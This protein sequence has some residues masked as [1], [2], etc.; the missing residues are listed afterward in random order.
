MKVNL[1][2]SDGGDKEWNLGGETFKSTVFIDNE[3]CVGGKTVGC[4]ILKE[5]L[6]KV[7][8]KVKD[9]GIQRYD[10]I[11][12]GTPINNWNEDPSHTDAVKCEVRTMGVMDVS[13]EIYNIPSGLEG[14][15][16]SGTREGG[17]DG[18]WYS[19]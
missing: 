11:K 18:S 6:V 17:M 4:V 13:G 7:F 8:N 2:T 16:E 12:S 10:T 1:K 19:K 15:L 9:F 5:E 3:G 14:S